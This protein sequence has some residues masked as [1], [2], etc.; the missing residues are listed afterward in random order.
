VG[1]PPLPEL[2]ARLARLVG[3]VTPEVWYDLPSFADT[4][5][6]ISPRILGQPA[7]VGGRALW[8]YARRRPSG[9]MERLDPAVAE[10]WPLVGVPVLGALLAG[11]LGWLGLVEVAGAAP[12]MAFRVRPEAAVLAGRP[13]A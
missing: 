9:R 2:R 8:W 7:T 4:V 13:L 1:P 10:G 3:Q 5:K 11:P 12:G 6:V